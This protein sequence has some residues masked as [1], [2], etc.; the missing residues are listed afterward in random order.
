MV[1][2]LGGLGNQLFQLAAGIAAARR[3][4]ARVVFTDYWLRHPEPGETRRA[5]A[6]NGLFRDGELVSEV[7]PRIGRLTERIVNK[8]VIE[9]SADDD[10][11][12]RV[13]KR[14]R[15]VVGYFQRLDYAEE[16]W[17]DL[18][19]RLA[20]SNNAAHRALASITTS[21]RGALHYRLGDYLSSATAN[22]H[23]GV[24]SPEYFADVIRRASG[25]H[26]IRRWHVISDDPDSAVELLT[27]VPLP[28][29][30]DLVASGSGDEWHD[31]GVLASSRVC[32][33]SN[34]SFSWWAAFIG[35]SSGARYVIAPKPWFSSGDQ[36]EPMLFPS[37]WERRQRTL[38]L[39]PIQ[40]R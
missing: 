14:T 33:I 5:V 6:L 26:G 23:H 11:L 24:T 28:A 32:A 21:D 10:A 16:A 37:S 2:L 39:S 15:A 25:L 34:S 35:M 12:A 20:S 18:R 31:L 3:Q 19:T 29:G 8:R 38:L 1:P 17:P 13:G 4:S 22:T 7:V 30:I 40:P 36:V 27:S 9:R